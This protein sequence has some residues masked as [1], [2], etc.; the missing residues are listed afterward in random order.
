MKNYFGRMIVLVEDYDQAFGF[1]N[2]NFG[3]Q[4]IFE[5]TTDV[6]QRFLH[7]GSGGTGKQVS[8]SYRQRGRRSKAGL[9]VRQV[10]SRPW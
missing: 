2:R 1:Y 10:N 9:A 4:K 5:L 3:F 7:I 6:G 8:G